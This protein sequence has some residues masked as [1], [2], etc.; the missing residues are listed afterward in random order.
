MRSTYY[1]CILLF[2]S[3][4][5]H[6]SFAQNFKDFSAINQ[7]NGFNAD[8]LLIGNNNLSVDKTLPYNGSA[9]N[10]DVSMQYV[11]MAV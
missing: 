6:Q 5:F 3:L 11:D 9:Y 1:L 4:G 7:T 8:I 10:D 2:W